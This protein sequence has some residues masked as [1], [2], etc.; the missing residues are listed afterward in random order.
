MYAHDESSPFVDVDHSAPQLSLEF[1][2]FLI[3]ATTQKHMLESR[4]LRF[5]FKDEFPISDRAK[6][7]QGRVANIK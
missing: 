2:V 3:N 4:Q 6:Y 7:A 5:W 1:K